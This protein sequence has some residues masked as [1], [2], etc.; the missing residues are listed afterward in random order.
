[1]RIRDWSSDVCSSD[2][3]VPV[4]IGAYQPR[5]DL[6]AIDR[7]RDDAEIMADRGEIE[8]REMIE[9]E[10]FGVG[11]HRFEMGR[12]IIAAGVEAHQ[13]LVAA[14]IGDLDDTQSIKRGE[15]PHKSEE[16]REG[17]EC[18]S[19]CRARWWLDV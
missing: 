7:R 18:V 5:R 17:K 8:A 1:M 19:R 13:M 3:P 15:Q 14:A 12:G 4:G 6:G 9:L 11:Q 16:R 2:L 10:P